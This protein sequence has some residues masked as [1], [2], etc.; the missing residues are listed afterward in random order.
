MKAI[1][2]E[3]LDSFDYSVMPIG[4]QAELT[5]ALN[6][7]NNQEVPYPFKA[8]EDNGFPKIH[9]GVTKKFNWAHGTIPQ[10]KKI[11]E[12]YDGVFIDRKGYSVKGVKNLWVRPERN[13]YSYNAKRFKDAIYRIDHMLTEKR[14]TGAI[15]LD[16]DEAV[17]AI[18]NGV[19]DSIIKSFTDF[20]DYVD[21]TP[22]VK[23]KC[24]VVRMNSQDGVSQGFRIDGHL[25]EMWNVD[26]NDS[27][28]ILTRHLKHGYP[29][30]ELQRSK[31]TILHQ[32]PELMMNV[33]HGDE[34]IH[35]IFKFPVG[36]VITAVS[37]PM[38]LL[39]RYA[40]GQGDVVIYGHGMHRHRTSTRT[41]HRPLI[42]GLNHPYININSS[43]DHRQMPL[44]DCRLREGN[45][46]NNCAGN[47]QFD[48][49]LKK[50]SFVGW[51]EELFTWL[52]TYRVGTTHPLNELVNSFYGCPEKIDPDLK[53]LYLDTIGFS[54]DR[55]HR[56]LSSRL[57]LD[58]M[59]YMP[60]LLD[61]CETNCLKK[62]RDTCQG[63]QEDKVQIKIIEVNN[64]FHED[65]WEDAITISNEAT[66]L[67]SGGIEHPPE[68]VLDGYVFEYFVDPPDNNDLEASM[69][70]WM[71]E[72]TGGRR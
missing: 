7:L 62:V 54:T 64:I 70:I 28:I 23:C 5:E 61:I 53:D 42:E 46:G 29:N 8:L 66:E 45:S 16:D 65:P 25:Q 36:K 59:S 11:K 56:H 38:D 26:R 41:W 68:S 67:G 4:P 57:P 33:F 27:Y 37:I 3:Y 69:L 51:S 60:K 44:N 35:P 52:S 58:G 19:K 63:Y 48:K 14:R 55:C 9:Y 71:N 49:P 17:D 10:T 34:G 15:W 39:V 20:K 50:L 40:L 72:Q 32:Y 31:V 12:W 6:V 30:H 1:L 43:M 21:K 18:V 2:K 24:H 47:I 22:N 13:K